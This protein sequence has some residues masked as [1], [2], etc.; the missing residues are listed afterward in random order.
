MIRRFQLVLHNRTH[1]SVSWLTINLRS[2]TCLPSIL[3]SFPM[4]KLGKSHIM[5]RRIHQSKTDSRKGLHQIHSLCAGVAAMSHLSRLP[6]ARIAGILSVTLATRCLTRQHV[7]SAR[8]IL[9]VNE[10]SMWSL[11]T[12]WDKLAALMKLLTISA[13]R[14][15]S[16]ICLLRPS[17]CSMAKPCRKT[18]TWRI[19]RQLL[20]KPCLLQTIQPRQWLANSITW[21]SV[22]RRWRWVVDCSWLGWSCL[23]LQRNWLSHPICVNVS[24]LI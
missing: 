19:G 18:S 10:S 12:F 5:T 11:N 14:L 2:T 7:L 9:S 15:T 4:D 16:L 24:F 21:R 8:C 6:H 20:L 23:K 22:S 1:S 3:P 13:K 17:R